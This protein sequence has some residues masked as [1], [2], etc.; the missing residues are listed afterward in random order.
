[1][2][3]RDLKGVALFTASQVRQIDRL[4]IDHHDVDGYDLMV[5]AG[6]AAFTS[7]LSRW[8]HVRQLLV[9]CGKGNNGGDGFVIAR[10][11]KQ[12]DIEVQLA[13]IGNVADLQGEAQQAAEDAMADGIQV[14][15][16]KD[17]IWPKEQDNVIVDALLG[18]GI[19]SDV[20]GEFA[21]LIEKA[22]GSGLPIMAIDVPSGINATT[23]H[24]HGVA[25]KADTTVT[26][27]AYKQGLFTGDGPV[28][29][30]QVSLASLSVPRVVRESQEPNCQL[31][32]WQSLQNLE[33]LQA[34]QLNAHKGLYGHVMIVGGDLGYGGAVSLAAQ[35]A[36]R[37]GAGLVS[38]ATRPEHVSAILA[39]CPE[40]MVHGVEN[41]Q[42]LQPL[43]ERADVIVIGP[44]LGQS[45][46]GE[47][48]LQQ[49]MKLTTPVVGDADALNILAKGKMG[50]NLADRV[51]MIT[52]HPGEAGRLL[53]LENQDIQQ[54]RFEAAKTLAEQYASAVVLK[55][56]GTVIQ[57]QRQISICGDGNPGMAS[58]GMGDVLSGIA[59]SLMAQNVNNSNGTPNLD[60]ALH[61]I[62]CAAV[63]LHSAAADLAAKD[64]EFGLLASDVADSVRYLLK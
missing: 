40:V 4:A 29:A 58:A 63:C 62:V 26:M 20:S 49:V 3:D 51:S 44:G 41:G 12:H 23:G 50:H 61:D 42:D 21:Q 43:L 10:L 8:P 54:D 56:L 17:L 1:M 24:K 14:L 31:I 22:N 47:Q 57:T 52:P 18:T 48:L 45:Y 6:E 46:W 53:G 34:R 2:H 35:A 60:Q 64:G 55:G 7:L 16:A 30:G 28:Y 13:L 59:G 32:R 19:Q 33:C 27:I 5:Q 15:G 38:V 25:I 11:A 39:R 9:L 36:L 37:S